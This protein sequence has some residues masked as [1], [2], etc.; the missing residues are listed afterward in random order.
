MTIVKLIIDAY[1]Y[2]NANN[3]KGLPKVIKVTFGLEKNYIFYDC[4]C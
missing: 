1:L 4:Y 3:I 2:L